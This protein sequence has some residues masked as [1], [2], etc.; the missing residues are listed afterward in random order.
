[1]GGR[2][3]R[4][5]LCVLCLAVAPA[6]AQT[7]RVVDIPTRPGV[8]Q[9]ILVGGPEK[10]KAAVI[11]FAGGHGG[12]MLT[13]QGDMGWGKGN[14]LVRTRALFAQQGLLVA[15][16]DAPSDRQAPP[17]LSGFRQTR[18]HAAD[19]KAVIAW[20]R[21]E[22]SVPVWLVGTSRGTQ[23]AAS[24]ATTLPL[25]EGGPDGIV[26]TS[27]ILTDPKGRPVP[28]MPIDKI[29]VPVL[30]VHHKLDGC[31]LCRYA[32]INALMGRLTASP[33]KELLTFDGG[34]SK[35][36]P[37]EAFAYH[38]YAGI[39]RDVVAKIGAWVVR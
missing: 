10:P 3:M 38:G 16:L 13:P 15:V 21:K 5:V 24:L 18:E 11:L 26:L 34:T 27:S 20:L 6:W 28:D 31:V 9:R 33:R 4:A 2:L 36:D 39:E 37:C 22:A 7:E 17:Y 19:V 32:D 14:F 30:V 35:G 23:S 12:L 25:A 1:M 8:T 29:K